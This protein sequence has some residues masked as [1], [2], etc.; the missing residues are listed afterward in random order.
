LPNQTEKKR[1]QK[2][3]VMDKF[4]TSASD[5]GSPEVQVAL[6]TSRINELTEHLRVHK[7]DFGT[8]RGLLKAVGQRRRM[9]DYLR[10]TDGGRYVKLINELELR[11]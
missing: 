10:G 5:T 3:K 8:Q 11:K 7:K 1:E 9:L 2:R 4:K 6:L